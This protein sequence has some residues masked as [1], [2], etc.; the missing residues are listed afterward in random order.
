MVAV[1]SSITSVCGGGTGTPTMNSGGVPMFRHRYYVDATPTVAD[2]RIGGA[3]KTILVGGLGKGGN[4]Y[5]AID[6]TVPG[7][8]T[9]ETESDIASKVM[10]EFTN[11]DLGHT[12]PEPWLNETAVA[13]FQA[14]PPR[15]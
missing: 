8:P 5:Y 12:Y 2:V 11:P 1:A 15:R 6:V 14:T 9:T 3:W 7:S 13:F 4:S 10:W